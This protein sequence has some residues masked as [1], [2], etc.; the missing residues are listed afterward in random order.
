M[1]IFQ[2][3]I[4]ILLDWFEMVPV[5]VVVLIPVSL[6]ACSGPWLVARIKYLPYRCW[7]SRPGVQGAAAGGCHPWDTTGNRWP[8]GLF[9][10]FVCLGRCLICVCL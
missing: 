1:V 10:G 9:V 6:V 3:Q 2:P 5:L 4:P 7:K 8:L